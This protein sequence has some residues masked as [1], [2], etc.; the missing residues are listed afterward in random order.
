MAH[1]QR[2]RLGS[3]GQKG[4]RVNEK[5]RSLC[6]APKHKQN[7]IIIAN[8]RANEDDFG[9]ACYANSERLDALLFDHNDYFFFGQACSI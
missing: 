1:V 8:A 9:Y 2:P 6:F 7:V 4:L 5:S 3:K